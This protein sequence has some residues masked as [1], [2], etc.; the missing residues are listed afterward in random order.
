MSKT[1]LYRWFGIGKIPSNALD[2]I[3]KEGVVLQDEGIGGSISFRNFRAPG[4][5][6]S[7]RRTWFSGSIVLT[8]EHFLAFQYS[9]PVIGVSWED[10]RI[11]SL[12]CYLEKEQTLCVEFDASTFHDDW[13]GNI[14]V[15]FSTP[16]A[17]QFLQRI[18]Q[19]ITDKHRRD[20]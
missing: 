16:K 5:Y 18:N 7:A 11:K 4:R 9:E 15:R 13:S 17:R 19:N 2:Q 12:D 8:H 3:R 1:L 14:K 10:H 6:S 20:G